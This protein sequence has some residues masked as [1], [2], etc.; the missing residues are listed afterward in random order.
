MIVFVSKN[1]FFFFWL[2]FKFLWTKEKTSDG[3]SLRAKNR[4]MSVLRPG[5]VRR[6]AGPGALTVVEAPSH[7]LRRD[8]GH[9]FS[10]LSNFVSLNK[11]PKC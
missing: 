7:R 1:L 11:E 5:A 10:Q 4:D 3:F 9:A 2:V 8:R 6:T